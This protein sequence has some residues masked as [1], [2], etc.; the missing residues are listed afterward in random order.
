[1]DKYI[2]TL[3]NDVKGLSEM[4]A[5]YVIGRMA[6]RIDKLRDEYIHVCRQLEEANKRHE[7]EIKKLKW[8]CMGILWGDGF[9]D[10]EKEMLESSGFTEDEI[11]T[12]EESKKQAEKVEN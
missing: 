9:F 10:F 2:V 8:D 12:F 6:A 11:K 5:G 3:R 4:E 1:M 7:A